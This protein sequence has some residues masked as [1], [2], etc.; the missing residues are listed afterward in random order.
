MVVEQIPEENFDEGQVRAFFES[1]GPVE[2]VEM[3]PYKRL[4]IV[5]FA[6][7]DAARAAYES[8]RVVFDNRFVKVYWYN[9]ERLPTA[10]GAPGAVNGSAG[11]TN[12]PGR[13]GSASAGS[14]TTPASAAQ[15]EEPAFDA[16]KFARDAEAAQKRLEERRA[17][18]KAHEEKRAEL[19]KQREAIER[20]QAEEKKKLL[21]KL[22]AKGVTPPDGGT[23]TSNKAGNDGKRPAS[24]T[25][26]ALR[27]K[28]RELEAEAKG[29]G[30]DPDQLSADASAPYGRGRG[31]FRGR[32][33]GSFRGA[34]RGRGAYRGGGAAGGAF[35]LDNRPKTVRIEVTAPD[36]AK[37]ESLR[38]FLFVSP[39]SHLSSLFHHNTSCSF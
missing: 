6:G 13:P 4:A 39:V 7:Y 9:P 30:L 33:R 8:P 14:P 32:G 25:T 17:A 24:A 3:R 38:Q 2:S 10:G 37:D 29:M 36:N 1:F 27:A 12:G 11:V 19:E 31:G 23:E 16:Q 18:Q 34:F 28:V 15:P 35:N 26:E 20:K 22:K 21:D 5:K